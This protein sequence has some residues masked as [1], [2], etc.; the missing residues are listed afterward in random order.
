MPPNTTSVLQP[1]DQG[2]IKTFK[3]YYSK[4][5]V[6]YLLELSENE[7]E[8]TPLTVTQAIIYINKAWR[9]VLQSTIVNCWIKVD[10]LDNKNI[11]YS[12]DLNNFELDIFFK[13]EIQKVTVDYVKAL[14]K[15]RKDYVEL[16]EV[17]H[18]DYDFEK[19]LNCDNDVQTSIDMTNKSYK[20]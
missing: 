11:N 1:C 9:Q 20:F 13:E 14:E 6:K 17:D 16:E 8:F 3:L 5:L 15:Y 18:L 12:I 4:I 19:Y 2:I 7:K 10:I